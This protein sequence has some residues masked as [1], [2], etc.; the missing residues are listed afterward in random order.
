MPL[1]E[2]LDA[3]LAEFGEVCVAGSTPFRGVLDQ[4]D[5]LVEFQRANAHSREYELTYRSAAVV[6]VRGQALTV[7]GLPY[8][9]REAPR[10]V[11]DGA[12]S[13]VLLTRV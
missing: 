4:P 11:D 12:F 7:A 13:R 2:D 3:F 6:L 1:A 8:T 5:E 9:V 10:Q